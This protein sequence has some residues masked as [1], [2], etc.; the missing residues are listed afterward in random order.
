M[1]TYDEVILRRLRKTPLEKPIS[2]PPRVMNEDIPEPYRKG[3]FGWLMGHKPD[4]AFINIRPNGNVEASYFHEWLA[5]RAME[6]GCPGIMND[7]APVRDL[8]GLK[9]TY[10]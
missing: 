4:L 2:L 5:E 8:E 3:F 6:A 10:L 9:N 7:K 1:A